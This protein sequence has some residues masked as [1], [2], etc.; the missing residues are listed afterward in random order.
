MRK[1]IGAIS[2]VTILFTA[3]CASPSLA[4]SK[5]LPNENAV[6][7]W[8]EARMK[9]A[10]PLELAVDPVSKIGTLR[11]TS[12]QP[13]GIV[14]DSDWGARGGLPQTAVGKVF[15]TQG[16][17]NYVC[18][19]SLVQDDNPSI[20]L[21]ITAGHC[22]IERGKFATN[23]MFVPNYDADP[24]NKWYATNLV[25]R[26]EFASQMKFNTKALQHDWAFAVIKIANFTKD[27]K[28]R[29]NGTVLPDSSSN[30]FTFSAPGFSGDTASSTGLGYPQGTPYN[31]C[32]IKFA[33]GSIATDNSANTWGMPSNLTGGASGGPW[34]SSPTTDPTQ[35]VSSGPWNSLGSVS[36]VNS[37]KYTNDSTRMYGPKFNLKTIRTKTVAQTDSC[38]AQTPSICTFNLVVTD[39]GVTRK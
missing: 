38:I 5:G 34:L 37:Y 28:S 13:T 14:D 16:T 12:P 23:W 18:S 15:F 19:G 36:S 22:V 2:L 29:V 10:L 20:A 27:G 33:F 7:Y 4:D 3:I 30:S 39:S 32:C 25:V 24:N 26:S 35:N 8:T 31:G 21:V 1:I 9:S 11:T 17:S 6:G